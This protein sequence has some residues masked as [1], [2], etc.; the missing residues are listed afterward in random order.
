MSAV[1]DVIGGGLPFQHREFPTLQQ[2]QARPL[3]KREAAR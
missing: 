3:F 1:L 2:D